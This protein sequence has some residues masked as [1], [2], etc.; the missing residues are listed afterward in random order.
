MRQHSSFNSG[1]QKGIM[2]K[3]INI[4][5]EPLI[6][7][8]IYMKII[9]YIGETA[10]EFGKRIYQHKKDKK[11][12]E[13]KCISSKKLS[14]LKNEYFRKYYELRW[15]N[16]YKPK[17]NKEKPKAPSLNL[18]LLKMFLWFENPNP[19]WLVPLS[20]YS[21]FMQKKHQRWL[22]EHKNKNSGKLYW[23]MN[24]YSKVWKDLD[25]KKKIYIDN[26]NTF[27]FLLNEKMKFSMAGKLRKQF[28][29]R[30]ERLHNG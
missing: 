13:V 14:F 1:Y 29:P 7:F 23:V 4:E 20:T 26:Q 11:F 8:L 9:V 5:N 12:D 21:P 27:K 10:T 17:Y 28:T 19:H 6:Y 22:P 24:Q 25:L 15:I 16:K 2:V 18:F 30:K 3:T